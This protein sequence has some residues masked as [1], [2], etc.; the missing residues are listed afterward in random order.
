M[1][2]KIEVDIIILSYAKTEEL[3]VITENGIRSLMASEDPEKIKFNVIIIESERSLMPFQYEHTLTVYPDA[4]FGYHRYMNIGIGMTS[5]PYICI[6]NNDLIFF[7]GWATNMLAAFDDY[8]LVSGSPMCGLF[9]PKLDYSFNRG[10]H[11][12]YQIRAQISGWCIFF[13]R[14]IL[15]LTGK[16]D[17]NLKFWYADNDYANTLWVLKLRH[18]LVTTSRVDHLESVTLNSHTK[19]IKRELTLEMATYW[20]KKWNFRMGVGWELID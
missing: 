11:L 20:L 17:E 3:K 4:E 6:C 7:K 16:L 9:H 8:N 19:E 18:G 14:E 15:K 12:G 2:V 1:E 5:S 13:K 10:V